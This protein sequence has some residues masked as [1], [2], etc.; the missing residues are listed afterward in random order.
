MTTKAKNYA[1]KAKPAF[2][3][4]KNRLGVGSIKNV[5][6]YD[7]ICEALAK[8][9][10]FC[11]E[12]F[13]K[14]LWVFQ[15]VNHITKEANKIKGA[16]KI[17]IVINNDQQEQ[18]KIKR[19]KDK[20]ALNKVISILVFTNKVERNFLV[21]PEIVARYVRSFYKEIKESDDWECIHKLASS[22]QTNFN[23]E[24]KIIE[25]KN[26]NRIDVSANEF[27][28]TYEWRKVRMIA[29][30]KYGNRC[31]CCGSDPSDGVTKINVD[32][33]K[34]RFSH[35]ELALDI[36]NL[37]ILCNSCN[38]GKGNWDSTDWRGFAN[39]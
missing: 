7:I 3:Y 1:F 38:H 20:L 18:L 5:K 13:S 4:V 25:E 22:V 37:Q 11:P 16:K 32:H 31:M 12:G 35:P 21:K 39:A 29:I 8:D 24:I 14:K 33:I 6:F 30:K 9:G 23:N 15:H 27:L 19:Q 28:S 26:K 2:D 10:I 36:N 34:P 17:K